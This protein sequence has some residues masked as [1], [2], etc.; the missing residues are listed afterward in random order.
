MEDEALLGAAVG[1]GHLEG[2]LDQFGAHVVGQSPADDP[3]RGQVDD[4]GQ[5]G[6]ALPRGDIGDVADIAP[7]DLLARSKVALNQ[8]AGRLG[9]RVSDRG[10]APALLAPPFQ[11]GPRMSLVTRRFPQATWR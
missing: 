4:G 2:I 11:A 3:A 1:E 7:V 9:I 5:V 8:V 6:P 10:L